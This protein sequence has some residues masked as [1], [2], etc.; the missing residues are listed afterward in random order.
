MIRSLDFTATP[1][2]SPFVT[3]DTSCTLQLHSKSCPRKMPGRISVF[4]SFALILLSF[5]LRVLRAQTHSRWPDRNLA[6]F[7]SVSWG[8][9]FTKRQLLPE[10]GQIYREHAPCKPFALR[11]IDIPTP[12]AWLLLRTLLHILG[13][14]VPSHSCT[15]FRSASI[16]S[17]YPCLEIPLTPCQSL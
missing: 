16:A 11:S 8:I 9:V 10:D 5:W 2:L 6:D 13:L 7:S 4:S 12:A 14:A 1:G 15:P 3:W 17:S